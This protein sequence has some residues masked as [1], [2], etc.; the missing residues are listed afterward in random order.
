MER[1]RATPYP[2]F[3]LTTEHRQ[4]G[5]GSTTNQ[6]TVQDGTVQEVHGEQFVSVWQEVSVLAWVP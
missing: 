6:R 3:Y 1:F 5:R 2:P 4:Q